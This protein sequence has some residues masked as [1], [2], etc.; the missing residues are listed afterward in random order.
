MIIGGEGYVG[1]ALKLDVPEDTV[2]YLAFMSNNDMCERNPE[3]A[4]RMNISGFP[5]VL[6]ESKGKRFIFASSVAAY[7]D[8]DMAAEEQ[9]LKPTTLYGMQ[10]AACE[11]L[12]EMSGLNYTIVRSASVCGVSP[13]MRYDLMVNRMVRDAARTGKLTVNGGEQQ[14]SHVHINDLCR[15]YA[16]LLE[17][18]QPRQTFNVVCENQKVIDTAT[19]VAKTIGKTEIEVKPYTDNRSYTVSGEKLKSAG[20]QF[21]HSIEE[22]IISVYLNTLYD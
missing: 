7:G 11:D 3:L 8:C 2:L 5:D 4:R 18:P 15:F 17:N 20:F 12:L 13:K 9:T 16:W 19:L 6:R 1:S 10:K 22:A 21:K 14:R